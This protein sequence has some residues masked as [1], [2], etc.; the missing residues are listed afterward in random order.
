MQTNRVQPLEVFYLPK[1]H[2]L[3][4][5]CVHIRSTR[6]K[7]ADS[8]AL[9]SKPTNRPANQP[10]NRPTQTRQGALVALKGGCC[11]SCFPGGPAPPR[12]SGGVGGPPRVVWWA[13]HRT[14]WELPP[15]GEGAK[16]VHGSR[17]RRRSRREYRIWSTAQRFTSALARRARRA[18]RSLPAPLLRMLGDQHRPGQCVCRAKMRFFAASSSRAAAA[19]H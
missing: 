1:Q 16:K 11:F 18:Y 13:S 19:A 9:E 4:S 12:R 6:P 3:S 5:I 14:L 8:S 2:R 10:T 7:S 17:E 15:R